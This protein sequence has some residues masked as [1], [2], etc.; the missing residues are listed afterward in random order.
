MQP[1]A[2]CFWLIIASITPFMGSKYHIRLMTSLYIQELRVTWLKLWTGPV[3]VSMNLSFYVL[4]L[5]LAIASCYGVLSTNWTVIVVVVLLQYYASNLMEMIGVWQLTGDIHE[6]VESHN[7]VLDR[8]VHPVPLF[9]PC[10]FMVNKLPTDLLVFYSGKWHGCI[11]G[12]PLWHY[13]PVQDGN[14]FLIL[15]TSFFFMLLIM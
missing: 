13:G 1:A 10:M 8:M 2:L 5:S 3:I 15:F 9:L 6:E 4:L 11:K 7:R 14:K 12:C